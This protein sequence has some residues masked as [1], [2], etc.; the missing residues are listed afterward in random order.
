LKLLYHAL[1]LVGYTAALAQYV[2][3]SCRLAE[4]GIIKSAVWSGMLKFPVIHHGMIGFLV[5]LLSYVLGTRDDFKRMLR[6][7]KR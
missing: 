1:F 2:E 3:F 6:R 5:L 7:M 4:H